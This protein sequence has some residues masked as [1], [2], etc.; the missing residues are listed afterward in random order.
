MAIEPIRG[1]GFRKVHGLYLVG[2]AVGLPCDRMP[3]RIASRLQRAPGARVVVID[4][5]RFKKGVTK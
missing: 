4:A 3:F 1:C 5:P 2:D